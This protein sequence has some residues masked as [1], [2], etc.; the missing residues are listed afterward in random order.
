MPSGTE[1]MFFI[2]ISTIPK[3]Q[4]PTYLRVVAAFR[5]EKSN[6]RRVRFTVGDCIDYLGDV[7]TKTA[8]LPTV[9]TLLNRV[10]STPKACFMTGDLKDFYLNTPMDHYE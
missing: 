7:S 9:K 10:I 4:K 8:N 2:P 5:P 1:T 6:P 3:G